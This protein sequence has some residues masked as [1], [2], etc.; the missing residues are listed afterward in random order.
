[1]VVMILE[2]VPIG[3]RGELSRW[4]I[5]PHAGVFVGHLTAMVRDR[6]WTMC[7]EMCRD[8]GVIQV[9]STNTEQ[10]FS[11]R[12]HGDTR[13]DIVDVDGIQLVRRALSLTDKDE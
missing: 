13:R 2:R 6:L 5:E 9:W 3:L 1:M 8:G 10:R 7:C 4:L 12:I 11:V